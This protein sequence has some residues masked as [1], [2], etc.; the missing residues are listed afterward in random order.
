MSPYGITVPRWVNF[1][2]AISN[3]LLCSSLWKL[4]YISS[5][6]TDVWQW[7]IVVMPFGMCGLNPSYQWHKEIWKKHEKLKSEW[8]LSMT[9]NSWKKHEKLKSEWHLLI[10]WNSWK[11]HEKLK[12]EWHLLIARNN[13]V[14]WYLSVQRWLRVQFMNRFNTLTHCG[15]VTPYGNI[16]LNQHW[17]RWWLSARQYQVITWIN[18]Q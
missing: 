10:A 16:D 13:Y 12:S 1:K 11:K 17:I 7:A 5:G 8:H 15:L 6:V 9:R 2:T 14:L 4:Q 18:F 3:K